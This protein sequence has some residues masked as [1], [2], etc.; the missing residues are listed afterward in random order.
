MWRHVG[1]SGRTEQARFHAEAAGAL[2]QLACRAGRA[3]HTLVKHSCACTN[4]ALHA[5]TARHA[6]SCFRNL[7]S[8]CTET[9]WRGRP[10]APNPGQHHACTQHTTATASLPALPRQGVSSPHR[11]HRSSSCRMLTQEGC[12]VVVAQRLHRAHTPAGRDCGAGEGQT[13]GREHHRRKTKHFGRDPRT[14]E[15]S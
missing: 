13:Q 11:N 14:Q 12:F 6:E 9:D 5:N 2:G 7:Q 8:L 15:T 10:R 3:A 4:A 1:V